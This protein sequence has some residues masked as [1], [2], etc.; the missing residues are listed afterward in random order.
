MTVMPEELSTSPMDKKPVPDAE[1][2]R[3]LADDAARS[4]QEIRKINRTGQRR[5]FDLVSWVARHILRVR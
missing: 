4:R 5:R 2:V 1:I 3:K